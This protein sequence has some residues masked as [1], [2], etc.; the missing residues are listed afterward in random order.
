VNVKRASDLALL[1]AIAVL[2]V[3]TVKAVLFLVAVAVL[4]LLVAVALTV[5]KRRRARCGRTS[6]RDQ[7]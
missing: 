2:F 7:T 6:S 4:L 5:V 3:A 1:L